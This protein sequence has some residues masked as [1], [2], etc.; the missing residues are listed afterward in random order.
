M[1]IE[2]T[3]SILALVISGLSFLFAWF[4]FVSN[5]Y[6]KFTE[7][8]SNLLTKVSSLRIEYENLHSE[9][10]KALD[11]LQKIPSSIIINEGLEENHNKFIQNTKDQSSHVSEFLRLTEGHYDK[12]YKINFV[13]FGAILLEKMRHHIESLIIQT[14]HDRKRF[15][16]WSDQLHLIGKLSG[17]Q[18][19]D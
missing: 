12:I 11:N 15:K 6:L 10:T 1:G 9:T 17:E 7:L 2:L 8:K 19:K 5:S 18:K 4:T 3:I 16:V 14:E 13:P